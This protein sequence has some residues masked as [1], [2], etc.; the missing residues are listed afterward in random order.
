V[1]P[2]QLYYMYKHVYVYALS[3]YTIRMCKVREQHYQCIKLLTMENKIYYKW[4]RVALK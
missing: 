1:Y 4:A 3:A 2:V